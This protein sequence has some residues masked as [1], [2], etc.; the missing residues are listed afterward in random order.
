MGRK[1]GKGIKDPRSATRVVEADELESG[2]RVGGMSQVCVAGP[3]W[4]EHRIEI[5]VTERTAET[6]VSGHK[7]RVDRLRGPR[8]MLMVRACAFRAPSTPDAVL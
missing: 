1:G 3:E 4:S 7:C 2:Q 5:R 8:E 6:I